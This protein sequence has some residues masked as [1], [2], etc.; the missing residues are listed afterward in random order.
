M[1]RHLNS[2]STDTV[3]GT[4]YYICTLVPI[5]IM[6]SLGAYFQIPDPS[7]NSILKPVVKNISSLIARHG[8]FLLPF[9]YCWVYFIRRKGK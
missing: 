4:N 5:L 1:G 9:I 8:Y 2:L 7:K 3:L 6:S